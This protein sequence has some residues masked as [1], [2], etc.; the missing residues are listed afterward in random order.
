MSPRKI[1]KHITQADASSNWR[2][3]FARAGSGWVFRPT[4]ETVTS[5]DYMQIMQAFEKVQT[6]SSAATR[7]RHR[8]EVQTRRAS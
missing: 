2:A 5:L 4:G 6:S 1:I 3:L 7:A 8:A